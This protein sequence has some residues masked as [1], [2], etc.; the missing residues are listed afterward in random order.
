MCLI[1]SR[2]IKLHNHQG[3]FFFFFG[4]ACKHVVEQENKPMKPHAAFLRQQKRR[5]RLQESLK[6]GSGQPVAGLHFANTRRGERGERVITQTE[7]DQ[8]VEEHEDSGK[9]FRRFFLIGFTLVIALLLLSKYDVEYNMKL[10]EIR[11]GRGPKSERASE[12]A[13]KF[14]ESGDKRGEKNTSVKE[15]DQY[16]KTLG[17]NSNFSSLE[18]AEGENEEK[19]RR[20]DNFRVKKQVR[21]A[22]NKHLEEQSALVQCG[23]SCQEKQSSFENA[24]GKLAAHVDRE[25]F[26]VLLD[27]EKSQN[28]RSIS[29]SKLKEKYEEKKKI[30]ESVE[31][32]EEVREM[33]LEEIRE[34]YEILQNPETRKYYL[35]YGEKPPESMWHVSAR[36][37]GWGQEIALGTFKYKL[38]WMWLDYFHSRFGVLGETIVLL[39]FLFTILLKAPQAL[40]QSL[41]IVEQLEAETGKTE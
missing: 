36:H 18:S 26:G 10:P 28:V 27:D 35:L 14:A 38:I 25:L 19:Q 3:F 41:Q 29:A 22:Y 21:E 23:R 20:L 40:Q 32:D 15:L 1:A 5:T 9:G 34:A 33:A 30:I 2:T 17:I 12:K 11:N 31:S 24:Y 16:F 7:W 39:L 37:G 8:L 13:D 4:S 6:D